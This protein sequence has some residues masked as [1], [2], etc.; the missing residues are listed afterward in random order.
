MTSEERSLREETLAALGWI[1]TLLCAQNGWGLLAV[2]FGSK[3]AADSIFAITFA[4]KSAGEKRKAA[5]PGND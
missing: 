2:V 5:L 4:V 1:A 3:A